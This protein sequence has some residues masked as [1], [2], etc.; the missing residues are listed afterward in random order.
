MSPRPG[1]PSQPSPPAT[2]YIVM[3]TSAG[4]AS[5][6]QVLWIS[7]RWWK[8]TTGKISCFQVY[9]IKSDTVRYCRADVSFFN[10]F[11]QG[12]HHQFFPVSGTSHQHCSQRHLH[13]AASGKTG[14]WQWPGTDRITTPAEVH[15]RVSSLVCLFLSGVKE[16]CTANLN[17]LNTA[18]SRDEA[19]PVRVTWSEHTVA[20][21]RVV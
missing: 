1:T 7:P 15:S 4:A 14:V 17:F 5:T 19:R 9:M 12:D 3:A 16:L 18:R 21:L 10:T 11:P 13:P 2:K 6:Q 20:T 8:V